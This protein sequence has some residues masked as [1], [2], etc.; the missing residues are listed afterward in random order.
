MHNDIFKGN[1]KYNN[2]VKMN[3]HIQYKEI[4]T[5]FIVY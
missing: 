3:F 1:K 5:T 2:K 4:R